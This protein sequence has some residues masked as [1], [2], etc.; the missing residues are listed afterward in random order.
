MAKQNKYMNTEIW[1][2]NKRQI[3]KTKNIMN[4]EDET[5]C[6]AH[7]I[8]TVGFMPMV[9]MSFAQKLIDCLV[10]ISE[11]GDAELATDLLSDIEK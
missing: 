1:H 2:L 6:P 7:S 9:P 4:W 11:K 5:V 8:E 10:E 3:R